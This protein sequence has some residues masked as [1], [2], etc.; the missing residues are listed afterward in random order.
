MWASSCRRTGLRCSC[1]ASCRSRSCSCASTRSKACERSLRDVKDLSERRLSSKLV[2]DGKLL[3]VRSDTVRLPDGGT[4]EREFIEHP[5]AVA[6]IALTDAGELVMERQYRYP[7][8][9]DMIEIP[10]GKI[11]AG[12]DPLASARRELKEET[13]YTAAQWLHVATINIAIAYSNE[14]IEIY[15]AKELKHEGAKLDEEEFLDVFTLP[16]A[17]A[18]AWVREGKITDSKTVAGLFWAE[19]VLGGE[20]AERPKTDI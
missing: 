3:K 15:L 7:L 2:Y 10:A 14:R 11:D 13:G 8:G 4:A 9:R 17:T 20:W 1:W 12:E 16:L 6:V 5:G 19:K 18:L